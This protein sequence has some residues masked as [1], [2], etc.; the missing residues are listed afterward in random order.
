MGNRHPEYVPDAFGSVVQKR[1]TQRRSFPV[2]EGNIPEGGSEYISGS[3]MVRI[4]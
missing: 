1:I 3:R 2:V 4:G